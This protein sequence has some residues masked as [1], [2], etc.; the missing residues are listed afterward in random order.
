[1]DKGLAFCTS[2]EVFSAT[3]AQSCKIKSLV[4]LGMEGLLV[5]CYLFVLAHHQEAKQQLSQS[6]YQQSLCHK[7]NRNKAVMVSF[8]SLLPPFVIFLVAMKQ[9]YD[10]LIK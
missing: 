4:L 2:D 6:H 1:M 10:Q 7:S 9:W 3:V 8:P 5:F